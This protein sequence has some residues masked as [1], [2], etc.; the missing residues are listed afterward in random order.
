MAWGECRPR[1]E[2]SCATVTVAGVTADRR[3]AVSDR[4]RV[5]DAVRMVAALEPGAG[6]VKFYANSAPTSAAVFVL[7]VSQ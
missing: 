2:A 7:E 1:R 5:T 4:T 3:V 6:V